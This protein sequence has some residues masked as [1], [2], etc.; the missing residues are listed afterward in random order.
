ML[1]L[2][3]FF[4]DVD[5]LAKRA[6]FPVSDALAQRDLSSSKTVLRRLQMGMK[7]DEVKIQYI[8]E[9]L[10]LFFFVSNGLRGIQHRG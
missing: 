2:Q 1:I 7:H 9:H 6:G 5:D 3:S 4:S 8:D 10:H